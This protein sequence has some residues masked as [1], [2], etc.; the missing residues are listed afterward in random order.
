MALEKTTSVD[1][2]QVLE[3]GSIQVR[4]AIKV[5]ED[6]V[7]LSSSLHRCA[8]TPGQD[9]SKE[10]ARVQAIAKA[11][12]TQDVVAAYQAKVGGDSGAPSAQQ[13]EPFP[14]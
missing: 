9:V 8:Y 4:H 14:Q 7:E 10:P 6:G 3:D 2:I 1:L 11:V 12:W 5:L 13:L